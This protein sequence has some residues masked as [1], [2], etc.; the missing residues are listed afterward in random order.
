[1]PIV[2]HAELLAFVEW[3]Q[4]FGVGI[5]L[6]DAHL[7]ASARASPE[8]LLWTRDKR[9]HTQAVRLEVAFAP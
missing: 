3:Q 9:L 5:G 8:T 6:M 7:L 4:L 1:M 2:S